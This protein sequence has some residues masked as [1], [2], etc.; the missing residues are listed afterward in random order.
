MKT[1]SI[2]RADLTKLYGTACDG[3]KQRIGELAL[4]QSGGTIEVSNDLIYEAYEAANAA[5][6]KMLTK[7]F[8]I[9]SNKITD[10][11][12][13]WD[14]VVRE[15]KLDE[16]KPSFTKSLSELIQKLLG[17]EKSKEELATIAFWKINKISQALNEGWKPDF[18]NYNQYK[19]YPYFERKKSGWV[20]CSD[21]F[22]FIDC[23]F[24]GSGYFYKTRELAMYAG[25]QFLD[26]YKD[27]L[28]E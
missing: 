28:P 7:H 6:K 22:D 14:D 21:C 3:W 20:L 18:T 13:T 17:I 9:V 24:L 15:L 1:Q 10:R 12:K 4:S 25:E 8:E 16:K 5:Q 11:I 27:Y 19:Y 2:S 23:A 26:I